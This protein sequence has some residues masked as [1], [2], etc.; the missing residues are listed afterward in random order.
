MAG[1]GSPIQEF[2]ANKPE[3]FA[4][5]VKAAIVYGQWHDTISQGLLAGAKRTLDRVG[6][7]YEEYPVSGSFELPIV[8][9]A[10][11]QNTDVDFVVALGVIIRGGTPHF[12]YVSQAATDGLLQVSLETGKP[13]GFGVL[14]LDNEQQGIDRAGFPDSQ[15]D[16]GQEA[17]IAALD[18]WLTIKNLSA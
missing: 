17:V 7:Q 2:L 14:T 9:K 16:K 11:L 4:K 6:A 10:V 15:E 13:V 8:S 3:D 5:G 1:H 18:A 12:E